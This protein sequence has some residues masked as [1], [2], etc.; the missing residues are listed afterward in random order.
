MAHI[1][2][3][4]EIQRI[5]EMTE[6]DG[7]LNNSREEQIRQLRK[8]NTQQQEQNKDNDEGKFYKR[9]AAHKPRGYNGEEDPVKFEDLIAYM[10]K[11]LEVVNCQKNLKVK[12]TSFYLE[13]PVDT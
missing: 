13:G 4:N 8:M 2:V 5:V 6:Q 7:M 11:L 3:N 9:F 10:E 1:E 12:L